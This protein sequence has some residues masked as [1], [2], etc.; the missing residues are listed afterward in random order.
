M[1]ATISAA[2][3]SALEFQAIG[4]RSDLASIQFDQI[5][6]SDSWLLAEALGGVKRSNRS[7]INSGFL[8]GA[9][10]WAT[11]EW[12]AAAVI[13]ADTPVQLEM[14]AS[15]RT[16]TALH[17]ECGR[18]LA[19]DEPC[20]FEVLRTLAGDTGARN[21]LNATLSVDGLAIL[22]W[23]TGGALI[24][25]EGLLTLEWQ[26]RPALL[27]VSPGRLLRSPGRIRILAGPGSIR[28]FRGV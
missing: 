8:V 5:V 21:E 12:A 4:G 19:S 10:L 24:V 13:T 23:L 2:A 9:D 11:A 22:E 3:P 6:S 28:P 15:W 14:A 18:R 25:S 16:D 1:S 26:G 27:M 17:A 7:P 20:Q